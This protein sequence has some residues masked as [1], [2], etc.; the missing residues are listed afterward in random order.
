M[1]S[2]S[3]LAASVVMP[4]TSELRE[5]ITDPAKAHHGSLFLRGLPS[6]DLRRIAPDLKIRVF[7]EEKCIQNDGDIIENILF[8]HNMTVSLVGITAGGHAVES[9]CVG[10]EGF[11]GVE[12]L[13]GSAGAKCGAVA[14]R[15]QASSIPLDRLLIMT[16]QLP[17]LRAALLRY[18]RCYLAGI[19]RLAACNAVH[20]IRQRACRRLLLELDQSEQRE[21]AITQEELGRALGVSRA[22]LNQI[23]RELRADG[24]IAYSRGHIRI[25]DA[26]AMKTAACE[27]YSYLKRIQ[28]V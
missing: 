9:A 10:R 26:E 7:N 3:E 17:S 1:S 16:H 2:L 8:P 14:R 20:S 12:T 24:V 11:V 4:V 5:A 19:A 22:S 23:C 15:G 13:L 27:C 25:K 28:I 21:V 6:A 18:A